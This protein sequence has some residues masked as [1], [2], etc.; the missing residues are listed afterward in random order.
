MIPEGRWNELTE[1]AK[2]LTLTD[3]QVFAEGLT[4]FERADLARHLEAQAEFLTRLATYLDERALGRDHA[5]AVR[6]QNTVA[7]QVRRAFGY[8]STPDVTF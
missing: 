3:A 4:E 2:T 1:R 8:H 7:R 5:T 6:R